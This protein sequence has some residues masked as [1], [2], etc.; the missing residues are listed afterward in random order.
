M[1]VQALDYY[2]LEK[3]FMDPSRIKVRAL[4][5]QGAQGGQSFESSFNSLEAAHFFLLTRCWSQFVRY[6]RY[7]RITIYFTASF[8]LLLV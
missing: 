2:E 6:F 5:I 8:L 4:F 1:H 3:H 7:I